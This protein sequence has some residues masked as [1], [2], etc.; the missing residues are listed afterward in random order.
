MSR[1]MFGAWGAELAQEEFAT[2][3]AAVGVL[4]LRMDLRD[5]ERIAAAARRM[6]K[7][8]RD[9]V[10][11]RL[12]HLAE[13]IK[14]IRKNA[15]SL[16]AAS[17]CAAAWKCFKFWW[18]DTTPPEAPLRLLR[19]EIDPYVSNLLRAIAPDAHWLIR[20][21]TGSDA[22]DASSAYLRIDEPDRA[23]AWE[24]PLR[25]GVLDAAHDV[26]L[27]AHVNALRWPHLVNLV[28]LDLVDEDCDLLLLPD[29]LRGGLARVLQHG[30]RL[31]ADCVLLI[32]GAG[33][34]AERI[35]QLVGTLRSEVLSGGVAVTR[36]DPERQL[37]WFSELMRE[38][39]HNAPLDVALRAA[40]RRL[41]E[42]ASP[43]LLAVSRR[44]AVNACVTVFAERLAQGV[45]RMA[46]PPTPSLAM[47]P[48][49]DLE[50]ED[51]GA[52]L[53]S[54]AAGGAWKSELGEASDVVDLRGRAEAQ[55]GA[56][57]VVPRSGAGAPEPK[58]RDERRVNY[59]VTDVTDPAAPQRVT[60]TLAAARSYLLAL[61]V[62]PPRLD[63][64]H[65]SEIFP[66]KRLPPSATGHWLDVFF[67][68]LVYAATGRFH[69]PQQG[70]LFLPPEGGSEHCSFTFRTHG[71]TERYEARI[72]I[73]H[74]NRV[75]Q[76][77]ML[78]SPLGGADG[79]L[80]LGVENVV[81]PTFD[82]AWQTRPFD[83]AIVVNHTSDGEAGFT[84]IVGQE[85]AFLKPEGIDKL[86]G[87]VRD[88]LS[89]E[90]SFT[91]ARSALDD[92][93][94]L[95]LF[96]ALATHGRNILKSM[97]EELQG[98]LPD[99][100]RIQIVEARSG[101]WL[102]VEIFY[103]VRLPEPGAPLCPNA[104]AA[105]LREN[106][107]SHDSCPH[108]DDPGHQCPMRFWGF[109]SVIER[110]PALQAMTGAEYTISIPQPGVD[111]LDAFRSVLLGA[112]EKFRSKDLV[113]AGGILET[114]KRVAQP[115]HLVANWQEWEKAV[116]EESPSLLLLLPHSLAD[117]DDEDLPA[118]EIGGTVLGASR[119]EREFVVG[120]EAKAPVVLL[121]GCSTQLTDVRFLNFVEGF[122]RNKAALVIGTLATIRG[123][124]TV[125]FIA[126]LLNGMKAAQGS[127]RTFGEVFLET[128]RK[129]LAEGDGF[130]MSLTAYGDVGWRM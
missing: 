47:L 8:V 53:E 67:V 64:G 70:R 40:V 103:S 116:R 11:L 97:P 62:G 93:E 28:R 36:V 54:R 95:K 84:T 27:V 34:P 109:S 44:L 123:R 26:E 89:A 82:P 80:A 85:V 43:P 101:A 1:A 57:I 19:L 115:P 129:L 105:L 100:A 65:A 41:G 22:V 106:G 2:A 58:A 12:R 60:A 39:S 112:S 98:R 32:G 81:A 59:T 118:L 102:P 30:R 113:E 72:V 14:Q 16:P 3:V 125:D 49:S 96:E 128:K 61:D 17:D 52:E 75:I 9:V 88:K 55:L 69:T 108:R 37:Y 63:A 4:G 48:Q 46:T 56:R 7:A 126:E 15:P 10:P 92:P 124:R 24:W 78:S 119:L 111:T 79:R 21:L 45:R 6:H 121:L 107:A 99:G 50:L 38:L 31:R 66:S 87:K 83:A 94:L 51:L 114:V 71:V 20:L 120:P 122:K 104:R 25:I 110:Q 13:L 73:C 18:Y 68:P 127:A 77:L 91:A 42:S 86:I 74:E 117:P 23:I 76:T 5:E 33:V 130:V 35:L 29:D 90:A